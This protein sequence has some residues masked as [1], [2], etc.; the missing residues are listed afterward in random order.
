MWENE[1]VAP[2]FPI[3]ALNR[4]D[5]LAS[6]SG[7]FAADERV[8]VPIQCEAGWAQNES[9]IFT[10]EKNLLLSRESDCDFLLF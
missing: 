8:A 5:W 7:R 1:F 9:E 10:K 2:L 6:R 3:L 4:G